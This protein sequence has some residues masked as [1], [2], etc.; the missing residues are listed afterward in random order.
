[1]NTWRSLARWCAPMALAGCLAFAAGC[2]QAASPGQKPSPAGPPAAPP[3]IAV[4]VALKVKTDKKTYRTK[5]PIKMT[6]TAVNTSKSPVSLNFA[7]GQRYDFFLRNGKSTAG[8][9]FWKWSLS[10]LFTQMIDTIAL[11]PG[12]SLTYTTTYKPGDKSGD[13]RPLP[14]LAPGTYTVTAALTVMGRGLSP[15]TS[16]TFQIK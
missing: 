6:L 5:E 15:M 16:T 10:R 12:K 14:S 11:E 1:M 13:G 4:P 7:T 2:A 8:K 3:E 9:P